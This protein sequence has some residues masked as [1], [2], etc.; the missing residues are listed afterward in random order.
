[1]GSKLYLS[2]LSSLAVRTKSPLGCIRLGIASRSEG[3]AFI[4]GEHWKDKLGVLC[5]VLVFPLRGKHGLN[6]ASPAKDHKD[7]K[8]LWHLSYLAWK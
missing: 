7:F 4:S 8:G 6:G 5:P 2:Q 1:M 3:V